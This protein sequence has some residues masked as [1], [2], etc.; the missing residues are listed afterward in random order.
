MPGG[1]ESCGA[2]SFGALLRQARRTAGLTQKQLA[3]RSGVSEREISDQ[4]RG[5]R[6]AARGDTV[7]A[8]APVLGLTGPELDHFERAARGPDADPAAR[9]G[10]FAFK[11]LIIPP[12][13]LIGRH[14]LLRRAAGM[15]T[16]PGLRIVTL[17]GPGGVGK[18]RLA[19]EAARLAATV[20]PAGVHDVDL[21]VLREPD[22]VAVHI[23]HALGAQRVTGPESLAAYIG[24]RRML[25]LL[26]NFEHLLAAAP[27]VSLLVTRCPGLSVLCTSRAPLALRGEQEL[28]VPPLTVPARQAATAADVSACAAAELFA[29][30]AQA[31]GGWQLTDANAGAVAAIC[32]RLDGMPLAIELAA[33]GTRSLSAGAIAERLADRLGALDMLTGGPRDAPERQR[34]LTATIAWSHDLLPAGLQRLLH[35][36]SVFPADWTGE[37]AQE[38]A[39]E[40][41][42]VLP[43]VTALAAS[44]LISAVPGDRFRMYEAVREFAAARL[45]E[46]GESAAVAARHTGYVLRLTERA[47]AE[48]TG[49][50]QRA[51]LDVLEAAHDDVRAALGRVLR[52][53]DA[54]AAIRI[55][56]A[57]WRFWY[58]R[59]HL[60]EGDRWLDRALAAAGAAEP[61]DATEA[62]YLARALSGRGATS[63]HLHSD[64]RQPR[65]CYERAHE[66]LGQTGDARG[67]AAIL[68]NLALLYQYYWDPGDAERLYREAIE[69]SRAC[70]DEHGVGAAT[71][72]LATLLVARGRHE[73]A[74]RAFERALEVFRAV[75]DPS[76]EA[77]TLTGQATLATAEGRPAAAAELA[78]A[79][80]TVFAGLGDPLGSAEALLALAQARAAQHQ[81]QAAAGLFAEALSAALAMEDQWN[82]AAALRGLAELA[83]RRGD[84]EAGRD[85]A[86]RALAGYQAVG[87]LAGAEAARA[88]LAGA[89]GAQA[90]G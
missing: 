90:V 37:A 69:A 26:D 82:G 71:S 8:L 36:L 6:R 41:G 44:N 79:A 2:P 48:L 78:E 31:V 76:G 63:Q 1:T 87:Y 60:A 27:L 89:G 12:T 28:H 38:V 72:N 77:Y 16:R 34:T 52:D 53:G 20:F 47:T 35:R 83:L 88:L 40:S 75:G 39:G 61:A 86:A 17:T 62:G 22:Q 19:A 9:P 29:W 30:H 46:D 42:P 80:R 68:G 59:G 4:E 18:T 56:G 49:P 58:S 73:E 33:A 54:A 66:L 45:S 7:R 25:V 64:P 11:Q 3:D 43:G 51:W 65:A 5:L 57:M 67:A 85:L 10:D 14:D 21:A 24:S 81:D 13:P 50:G 84:R 32:R 70:G 23:G 55:A 74:A 15:L